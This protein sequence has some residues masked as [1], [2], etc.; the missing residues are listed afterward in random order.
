MAIG[1]SIRPGVETTLQ[2][3]PSVELYELVG[4]AYPMWRA[5]EAKF[6]PVTKTLLVDFNAIPNAVDDRDD[7]P[8]PGSVLVLKVIKQ[9]GPL[10][11]TVLV[12]AEFD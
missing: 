9:L 10:H 11:K 4:S 3:H 6:E 2:Y 7:N 1:R 5:N 12:L 8:F